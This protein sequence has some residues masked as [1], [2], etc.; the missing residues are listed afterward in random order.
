MTM[1]KGASVRLV[2]AIALILLFALGCSDNNSN[3]I[4][5]QHADTMA[6]PPVAADTVAPQEPALTIAYHHV[7]VAGRKGL[8][9]LRE[10]VGEEHLA[11]ILRLNRKDSRH[12]SRNDTLI[13]PDTL[14]S[15]MAYSPFPHYLASAEQIRKLVVVD[16]RIQAIAAYES[17]NIVFWGPTSTGKKSTPTDTGLFHTN[18]RSRKRNSTID[19]E[20]VMEWYWNLENRSGVSMHQYDLPGYPA[21]HACVR[22]L[23]ED[24]QWLYE[25]CEAWQLESGKII[26]QGTPVLIYNTY[27]FGHTA[28][29]KLLVESPDTTRVTA[30]T[31]SAVLAVHLPAITREQQ[32]RDS[33]LARLQQPADTSQRN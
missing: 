7:P 6:P 26:V 33:V 31:L 30:E 1:S 15:L 17:G 3:K 32:E 27:Q 20:W 28:P 10:I 4:A 22:L 24:A 12:V 2:P 11:T 23:T 14:A 8:D 13:V 25:W 16:Q 29:W 9:S 5:E 18:W 19:N 21:S